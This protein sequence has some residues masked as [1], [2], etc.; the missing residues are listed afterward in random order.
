M[1]DPTSAMT[2]HGINAV[3]AAMVLALSGTDG[4]G[5]LAPQ[6]SAKKSSVAAAPQPNNVKPVTCESRFGL[7]SAL[8][9]NHRWMNV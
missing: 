9:C 8:F 6:V 7:T 4:C 3:Q 1:T 2:H 5:A